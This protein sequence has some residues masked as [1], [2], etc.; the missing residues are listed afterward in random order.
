LCLT[1]ITD[2]FQPVAESK[3]VGL[4]LIIPPDLPLIDVD[5]AR[6]QQVIHNLLSNALRHTPPDGYITMTAHAT[7]DMVEIRVRD[8]GSGIAAEH[9]PHIFER[10]YRADP[11]RERAS[12]GTGLGLAISRAIVEAHG[13]TISASSAGEGLG[14]EM[15]I[16]LPSA[17]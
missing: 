17:S 2:I 8:T 16:R 9:L 14:T 3:S 6:F 1:E 7:G 11:S 10:F 15:I 4:Q 12:G 5:S 13:G